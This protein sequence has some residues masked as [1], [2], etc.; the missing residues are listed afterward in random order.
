LVRLALASQPGLPELDETPDVGLGYRRLAL[1]EQAGIV[2]Q[3]DVGKSRRPP[4]REQCSVLQHD[5]RRLGERLEQLARPARVLIERVD[6][7]Q[8]VV[9]QLRPMPQGAG[10]ERQQHARSRAR[11]ARA[12]VAK[13]EDS[14]GIYRNH[15]MSERAQNA[16]PEEAC[17]AAQQD[18]PADLLRAD[19]SA[20][21]ADGP[22]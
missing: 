15:P 1:R 6:R 21:R 18:E 3:E 5:V 17:S 8:A 12:W 7:V 10:G 22:P 9:D 11:K 2:E 4:R 16:G 13:G 19:P 14:G 20:E